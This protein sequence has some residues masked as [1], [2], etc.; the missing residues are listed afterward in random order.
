MFASL[1]D[2]LSN[3]KGEVSTNINYISTLPQREETQYPQV[4]FD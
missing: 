3:M 4:I 1:R 2:K